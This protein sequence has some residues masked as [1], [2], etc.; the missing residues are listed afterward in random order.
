M[1]NQAK[2]NQQDF[3]MSKAQK[4]AAAGEFRTGTMPMFPSK[5]P[6]D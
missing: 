1:E 3:L 5:P 2:A 6:W 4:D